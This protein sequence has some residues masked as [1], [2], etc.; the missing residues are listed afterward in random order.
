MSD[1]TLERAEI[2]KVRRLVETM[3][4]YAAAEALG[5]HVQTINVILSGRSPRNATV[6]LLRA[7][8]PKVRA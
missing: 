7:S 8:I 1:A 5:V 4:L 3:G 6:L 2:A